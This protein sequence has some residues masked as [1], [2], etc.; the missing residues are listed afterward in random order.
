MTKASKYVLRE[1]LRRERTAPT[2]NR[3]VSSALPQRHSQCPLRGAS[4]YSLATVERALAEMEGGSTL[5]R[6]AG[7]PISTSPIFESEPS[8]VQHEVLQ[9]FIKRLLNP[10]GLTA[11]L[12]VSPGTGTMAAVSV[13]PDCS[14]KTAPRT[15]SGGVGGRASVSGGS[16][17]DP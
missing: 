6:C 9:N 11:S 12:G 15:L 5:E 1:E 17:T 4:S 8:M 2:A 7:A 10:K 13:S 14:E 3:A 16:Q